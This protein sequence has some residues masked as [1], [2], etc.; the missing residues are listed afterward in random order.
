MHEILL[1]LRKQA[2]PKLISNGKAVHQGD[3]T[4]A[5]NK[6]GTI[7][8]D[9]PYRGLTRGL[10]KEGRLRGAKGKNRNMVKAME[11]WL[12]AGSTQSSIARGAA[13]DMSQGT[14]KDLEGGKEGEA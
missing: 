7:T 11:E 2:L 4:G 3:G 9:P 8:T 14:R 6:D 1:G 10:P 5:Q 12:R 13:E